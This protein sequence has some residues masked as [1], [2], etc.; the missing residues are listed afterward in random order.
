MDIFKGFLEEGL[1]L[2]LFS[3]NGKIIWVSVVFSW[4][5][6]SK[7]AAT[8]QATERGEQ[9]DDAGGCS[10]SHSAEHE[11]QPAPSL[12]SEEV[13]ILQPFNKMLKLLA[14]ALLASD[15][16]LPPFSG[17]AEA[18]CPPDDLRRQQLPACRG[19]AW[20]TPCLVQMGYLESHKIIL[21]GDFLLPA[22]AKESKFPSALTV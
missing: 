8:G 17:E 5:S 4:E 10:E 20:T 21:S 11:G 19:L 13:I 22:M 18:A 2:T 6:S 14:S 9:D 3:S 12:M 15:P 1:A 16:L 7:A